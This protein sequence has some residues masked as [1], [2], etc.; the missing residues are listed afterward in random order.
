MNIMRL[1]SYFCGAFPLLISSAFANPDAEPQTY[2]NNA[3]FS[4]A[5]YI[6][7]GNGQHVTTQSSNLCPNTASISCGDINQWGWCCPSGYTCVQPANQN[8]ILG[9][10]P[11]GGNCAGS[12]NVASIQTVTVAA[13]PQ[14]PT[15]AVQPQQTTVAVYPPPQAGYCAT[16]TMNG[17]GLP[18]TTQGTCG[19]ILI[20]NEGTHNLKTI[21]YSI[22]GTIVLLHIALGRMFHWI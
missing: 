1:P 16:L 7:D 18:T 6:V 8:S 3:P 15:V 10:C 21:G 2:S 13:P 4:G 22:T 11:A 17:P 9:C 14:Q 20:V 19:T 12:V 5:I